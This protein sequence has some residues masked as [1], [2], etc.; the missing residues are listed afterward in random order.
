MGGT[1]SIP[2]IEVFA[3]PVGPGEAFVAFA[4]VHG[5]SRLRLSVAVEQH[6]GACSTLRLKAIGR[7]LAAIGNLKSCFRLRHGE[8]DQRFGGASA[9]IGTEPWRTLRR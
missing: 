2:L 7:H 4:D 5:E 9:T 1:R 6:E 8:I 3:G